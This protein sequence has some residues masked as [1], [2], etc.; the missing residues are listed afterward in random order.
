MA[1]F[2][3]NQNLKKEGDQ[4]KNEEQNDILSLEINNTGIENNTFKGS[5]IQF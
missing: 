5:T 2:V 4:D 1:E 3:S